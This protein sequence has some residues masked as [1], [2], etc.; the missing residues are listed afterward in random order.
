MYKRQV[1]GNVLVR[2]GKKSL[3]AATQAV[4]YLICVSLGRE[5]LQLINGISCS[6]GAFSAFRKTALVDV[7]GV[8]VGGGEDFDLTLRLRQ[9]GWKVAFVPEAICYTDVPHKLWGYIRQR[10]RWER[11]SYRLRY[12]KH[13]AV[14]NPFSR[15]FQVKELF[16]QFD[17]LFFNII[18]GLAMPIYLVWLFTSYS[19]SI[20]ILAVLT[21]MIILIIVNIFGFMLAVIRSGRHEYWRYILFVPAYSISTDF[22][23]RFVRLYAYGEEFFFNA[24]SKD[25]FVPQRVRSIRKW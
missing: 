13:G 5:I 7:Q 2:N 9:K 11:D 24:S 21:T 17:F 18:A 10:L 22:L 16:H 8:D 19:A 14:I 3:I 23:M 12:R 20:A 6:S 4:E 15:R 25:N 1:S